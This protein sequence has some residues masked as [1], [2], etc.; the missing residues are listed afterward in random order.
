MTL[1]GIIG[2]FVAFEVFIN[3]IY[4]V[5]KSAVVNHVK[6]GLIREVD[7][8]ELLHVAAF[9]DGEGDIG[10]YSGGGLDHAF[11]VRFH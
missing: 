6:L 8:L 9:N 5:K 10:V 7:S 4:F 2:E 3:F 1:Q 11:G